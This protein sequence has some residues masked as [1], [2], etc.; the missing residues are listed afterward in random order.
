MSNK[1]DDDSD[2]EIN[3]SQIDALIEKAWNLRAVD[4]L[5]G[6]ELDLR[7]SDDLSREVEL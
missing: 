1:P 7:R 2:I 6:L 4:P 5:Q 3:E